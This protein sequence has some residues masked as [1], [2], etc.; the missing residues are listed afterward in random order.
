MMDEVHLAALKGNESGN[1][2]NDIDKIIISRGWDISPGMA[3]GP[4]M[5]TM[6]EQRNKRCVVKVKYW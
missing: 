6:Q 2:R 4:W 5:A 3:F 1:A